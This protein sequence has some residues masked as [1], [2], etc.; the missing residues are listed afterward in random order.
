MAGDTTIFWN[1][2]V[3]LY[4]TGLCTVNYLCDWAISNLRVIYYH[5]NWWVVK[6][7]GGKIFVKDGNGMKLYLCG[8]GSGEQIAYS[9]FKFSKDLDK[10]KPILYIPLAMN[11]EK[12]N[13][14]YEWFNREINFMGIDKFDMVRSS[15]ELLEKNFNDYCAIFIGGGNTFKL[16]KEIREYNNYERILDYLENDGIVFGSSAGAIIFGKDINISLLDDN[17]NIGL[18]DTKSFNLL[19]DYSIL[20]HLNNDSFKRNKEYLIEYSKRNKVIYIPEE[21][22]ILVN[23]YKITIIGNKEYIIFNNGKLKYCLNRDNDE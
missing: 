4:A 8:G 3:A 12:Y 1:I 16:L 13:S 20:C 19:N 15:R 23:N 5:R 21:I 18:N 9:L 10:T 11:E 6:G 17:N 2:D 7:F 22:V 14:C